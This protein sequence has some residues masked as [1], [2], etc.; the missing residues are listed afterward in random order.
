MSLVESIANVAVGFFLAVL[1]QRAVFLLFGL[2]VPLASNLLIGATFTLV[3]IIRS[4]ALRRLFEAFRA[5]PEKR[6]A[7]GQ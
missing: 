1:V 5:R 3:S 4:Y 7:A 6:N 2:E